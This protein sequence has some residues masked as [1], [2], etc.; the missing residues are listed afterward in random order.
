ME[1]LRKLFYKYFDYDIVGEYLD[2]LGNGHYKKRYI[3][4]Y[5]LRNG[6]R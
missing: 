3:K 4:R 5:K 6:K 1:R 2:N